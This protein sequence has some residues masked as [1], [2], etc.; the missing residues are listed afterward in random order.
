MADTPEHVKIV[1]D[2]ELEDDGIGGVGLWA[3]PLGDDLYEL[4]N[5]P[6][7]TLAIN[8]RDIVRAIASS[9]DKNPVF[10]DVVRR[11]GHRTIHVIFL[12]EGAA[13]KP[14]VLEHLVSLG[15]YYEGEKNNFFAID[16]PP[17]ID[18]DSV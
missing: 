15:T 11:G 13:E 3:R 5:T 17:E 16:L 1:I 8:D 4:D 6:W 14:K 7:H 10:V 2:T 9:P 12:A 18:F